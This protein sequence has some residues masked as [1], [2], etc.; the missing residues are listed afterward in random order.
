MFSQRSLFGGL[1]SAWTG[2]GPDEGEIT[3]TVLGRIQCKFVEDRRRIAVF[4]LQ[5]V[6]GIAWFRMHGNFGS[7]N[8]GD[9]V[10]VAHE[11]TR[12]FDECVRDFWASARSKVSLPPGPLVCNKEDNHISKLDSLFEI[13]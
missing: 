9:F 10:T 6:K 5:G 4:K 13:P 12:S 2:D 8:C 11:R 1:G 3:G 7:A